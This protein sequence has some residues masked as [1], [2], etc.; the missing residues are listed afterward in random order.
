[1]NAH[2]HEWLTLVFLVLLLAACQNAAPTATPVP[3]TAVAQTTPTIETI[4]ATPTYTPIPKDTA[5]PNAIATALAQDAATRAAGPT[6]EPTATP[7]PVPTLDPTVDRW[8]NDIVFYEV[9]VRSFQDSD[10]DGIGD[11]N[12]LIQKLD[13]LN[14]GDP[15]TTDDLG[16]T[17]LWLMPIM[18][19]PSYHGYDVVDYYTVEQDYGTNED[20]KRLI[21]EAHQRGIRVTVDLVIN[22][23]SRENPWFTAS[24]AGD[25]EYR[26]WYVWSDTNPGYLGPWGQQVWY[27]G[28]DGYYYAVF[29]SGMPDLNLNNPDVTAEIDNIVRFWLED[30]GVDG[31]RMDAVRHLIEN[32]IAQEN[33]PAT[34]AWLQAF[35]TYYKGI[36]PDAFTVG[37]TWTDSQNAAQYAVVENDI[38]FEFDLAEEY[39]RAAGSPIVGNLYDQAQLVDASY[40]PNQFGIFLTNHDQNRVMSVLGDVTKAKVGAALLLTSPGVPFLYYGEEIGMTGT[41][42]DEDIR[43]PM[44]WNGDDAGVG[45]TTSIPW[46]APAADYA[47]FNVAA[48]DAD[49]DSLLNTYRTLIHLRNDHE[50]LREGDWTPVAANS[51]RLYAF[52]RHTENETILVLFNLNPNVV[53]AGDYSLELVDGPLRGEVTAVS[54]YG[55]AVS[56]PP[57]VNEAGGFSGYMPLSEIQGQSATVILLSQE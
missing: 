28:Q 52:L 1:M 55:P 30:M 15:A 36:N 40:P 38:P 33:T 21:E 34:H 31:F 50:A 3:A 53:A 27:T 25:P 8:W 42:P 51:S 13:Y 7:R 24:N 35:H 39:L 5:T 17:G 14:D 4:V 26:D 2:K 29:W 46:R 10:G 57:V 44:P 56:E 54:L 19:S 18:E 16:I 45:F 11:I 6:K 37:E 47:E 23:T 20:F 48:E 43:L 32:G 41:K 9:F 49:P 12:G 22:H